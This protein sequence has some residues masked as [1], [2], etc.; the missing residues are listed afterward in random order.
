MLCRGIDFG[1]RYKGCVGVCH[2]GRDREENSSPG[3]TMQTENCRYR[4][5]CLGWELE[6]GKVSR[7]LYTFENVEYPVFEIC[8]KYVPV[9]TVLR[10]LSRFVDVVL[11]VS[12]PAG[13]NH[14]MESW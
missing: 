9:F 1:A 4:V 13:G 8:L 7:R 14:S 11:E 12:E 2:L 5:Q 3:K 6:L 10:T